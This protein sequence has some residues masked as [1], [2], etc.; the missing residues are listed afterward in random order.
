MSEQYVSVPREL[1]SRIAATCMFSLRDPDYKAICEILAALPE[2]ARA[3]GNEPVGYASSAELTDDGHGIGTVVLRENPPANGYT[4]GGI[5]L[6]LYR[7]PQRPMVLPE[8]IE[9]TQ[10]EPYMTEASHGFNSCL[11]R[12]AELNK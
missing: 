3:V 7:H 9:P 4:D 1:M 6:P 8:R 10:D 12:I 5:P 11:D 2:D